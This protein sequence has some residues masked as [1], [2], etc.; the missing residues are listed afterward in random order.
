MKLSRRHFLHVGAASL[1]GASALPYVFSRRSKAAPFGPLLDDPDGILD[2][3]AGFRYHVLEHAGD[4]MDD[5]RKVPLRPDG[6]GCFRGRDGNLVLM[7][8]HEVS[9]PDVVNLGAPPRAYAAEQGGGVTRVVVDPHSLRRLGSNQVLAGTSRNCAGGLSPWGW[10]SC[11]ETV[12]SGHGYVFVCDPE[13]SGVQEP[14]P[15]PGYGRFRHEAAAVDP[16]NHVAYLT[17]DRDDSAFYRFVPDHRDEPFVGRL[18]A[19]RISGEPGFDTSAGLR[20]GDAFDVAWADIPTPDPE[21]DSVRLQAQHAGAARFRRGEGLWMER[22]RAYF[23]CTTGGPRGGGQ[24][25]RL[26]PDGDGGRLTLIA[27]S[28]HRDMLDMPDNITVAPWGDIYMAEDGYGGQLV[29]GLTPR[30]EVFDFARNAKSYSELAGICFSPAG[31]ALFLNM[32]TDGLTL[33]IRGP[34]R[35]RPP[36]ET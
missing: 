22:G 4:L 34:F 1:V 2:L 17:E 27:Q 29:R 12:D 26:D 30:G 35:T 3:P 25:F 10:L 24:I 13:A 36:T 21:D 31:D 19:L 9:G 5:G 33:A 6:M 32:Q 28:E 16:E 7:R 23:C 14:H 11:E 15:V 8:N 18:Q 20:V